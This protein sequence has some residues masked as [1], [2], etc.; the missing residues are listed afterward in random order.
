MGWP[1]LLGFGLFKINGV[2]DWTRGSFSQS[3]VGWNQYTWIESD[4]EIGAFK[5]GTSYAAAY[6]PGWYMRIICEEK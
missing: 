6:N 4:A 5:R 1:D 2:W 3:H